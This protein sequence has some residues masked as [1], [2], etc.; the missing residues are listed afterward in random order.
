[1]LSGAA[2]GSDQQMKVRRSAWAIVLAAGD[3]KRLAPL[4]LDVTG[5]PIPKQ[6]CSLVG[7]QS[8]LREA[9]GRARN[10]VSPDRVC[11]VVAERHRQ[12]WSGQLADIPSDNVLV[13]PE[14][15]G[16]AHGVLLGLLSVL[17]RDPLA[18]ILFLPADHYVRDERA[19]TATLREAMGARMQSSRRLT[20][21][22]IGPE[23]PD[24]DLGYILPG[25][26]L[27]AGARA[28]NQFVEKPEPGI[29]RELVAAGALWN[30]FIFA[31]WGPVLL[32]LLSRRL[33]PTVDR[34]RAAQT[35]ADA[36]ALTRLYAHLPDVDF[37]TLIAKCPH[38]LQVVTAPPCG[39]SDLGVPRRLINLMTR[40]EIREQV[41]KR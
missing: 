39:W 30:S 25:G 9:L 8:L 32:E 15:R 31:A 2:S 38:D 41:V 17:A 3:G 5:K 7:G 36:H 24:S 1:M 33:G 6:F 27:F 11:M 29:A 10:I 18:G 12:Y 28:V 19:F 40:L 14:N 23:E 26:T 34:M 22:G 13:Q 16:T 37:S 20:L 21:I 4:T 35:Q